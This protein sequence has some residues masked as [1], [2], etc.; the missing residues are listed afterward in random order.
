MFVAGRNEFATPFGFFHQFNEDLS[1]PRQHPVGEFGPLMRDALRHFEGARILFELVVCAAKLF[2]QKVAQ[3]LACV[4]AWRDRKFAQM[5]QVLFVIFRRNRCGDVE[6]A[7]KETVE[8]AGR[9]AAIAGNFGH[10]RLAV[11][12]MGKSTLR[13]F[14]NPVAGSILAHDP[15]SFPNIVVIYQRR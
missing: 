2:E 15:V 6:L 13:S 4:L 8:I 1:L 5:R 7:R 3:P 9:H 11:A 14:D 10:G 12:E